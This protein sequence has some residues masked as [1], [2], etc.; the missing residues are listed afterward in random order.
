MP[1]VALVTGAAGGIG[2]ATVQL[3][4]AEGIAVVM[5]DAREAALDQ[6]VE[7]IER[8]GA[9]VIGALCDVRNEA[10]VADAVAASARW[11]GQ[12][13]IVVNAAGIA[14]VGTADDVPPD[15]WDEML[16]VNLRGA[17]LVCRAAHQHLAAK[18]HGAVVNVASVSG[19]TKSILTDPSYVASK[20]GVIGLTR[21]L[22]GQWAAQG[23]RVNCVAPGLTETRMVSIYTPEQVREL[24]ALIPLRRFATADEVAHAI[25]FLASERASYITGAVLDVNGGLFMG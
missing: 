12:I 8:G 19:R 11:Q 23:I 10:S 5:L 6:A 13:D 17:Y 9:E 2:R 25:V 21:S 7:D 20:A 22:A 16:N 1:L 4:A 24:E 3:L 18:G 15:R 14:R